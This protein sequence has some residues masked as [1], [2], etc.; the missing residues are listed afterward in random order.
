MGLPLC[1]R[2]NDCGL[3]KTAMSRLKAEMNQWVAFHKL[4]AP[5]RKGVMTFTYSWQLFTSRQ[6]T[7]LSLSQFKWSGR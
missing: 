6:R 1:M 4:S 2:H 3:K 5:E 7:L